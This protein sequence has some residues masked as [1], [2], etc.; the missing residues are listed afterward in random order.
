MIE[1]IDCEQ[2]S[3]SWRRARLGIP[4]ASCFS[5]ILTKGKGSEPSKTRLSYMRR[6]AAEIVLGEPLESFTNGSIERGKA[7]E[8]EARDYYALLHDV[9]PQIVG[10]I[11][12]GQKGCSPDAFIGNDGILEIKTSR[13]DLL[14]EIIDRDEVPEEH[15]AQIQGNLWVAE[16]EWLDLIIYYTKMP[17]FIKR[18][19]RDESYIANL[20]DAVEIFNA[21]LDAMV[22]RIRAYG[23]AA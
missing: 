2:G 15:V 3:E 17:A 9:D 20:S 7:M 12:N 1:I 22:E 14:I 5:A 6:L 16:R 8:P 23:R 18:S 21:E 10:F 13:P 11:R 4:T 19:Y